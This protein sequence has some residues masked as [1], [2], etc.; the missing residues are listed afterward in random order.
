MIGRNSGGEE[1]DRHLPEDYYLTRSEESL[2]KDICTHFANVVIV[3]NVNGLID[4]SWMKNM[5]A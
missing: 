3:L 5:R 4:L 2:L 1:C